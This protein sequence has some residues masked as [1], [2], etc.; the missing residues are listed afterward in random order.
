MI[1]YEALDFTVGLF[2]ARGNIVSI[3]LGLPMF[4]R[5]MSETVQGQAQALRPGEHRS[6]RHPAHQRRL[7]HRLAPQPH[8]VLG[9]DLPRR[10]AGRLLVLHGALAGRRRHDHRGHHRHLLR[11]PADADRQ[12]PSQGRAERGADRPDQDERP[13]AR[14]RDGRF[15]RP[16]R[17]GEDRRAAL[18]GHDP[19]IRP[20]RSPR[21]HRGDHG[22]ERGG[23]ARARARHARRRLR[24]RVVHGRRRHQ[25]RPAR[26]DQ[27]E[28]HRGRRPHDGRSHRRVEAGRRASTTPAS[29]RAIPA[30]RWRSSA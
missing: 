29:P 17:R 4:I 20:R 28:G 9:A 2:D 5:G 12:D 24:G 19:Q 13:P 14:A 18:H 16:A 27:R 25:R 21:R 7:H 22:P 30:P 8:D 23:G 15:P 11:R 1:I 26:A 6:G 10:R 3:G